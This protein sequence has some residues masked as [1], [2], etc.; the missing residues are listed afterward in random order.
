MRNAVF[1][2]LFATIITLA[3]IAAY[4]SPESGQTAFPGVNG[5]IAFS[6]FRNSEA[7]I[8]LINPVTLAES[9]VS[10]TNEFDYQPSF[11]PD[12]QKIAYFSGPLDT[13]GIHVLNLMTFD[14]DQITFEGDQFPSWSPDGMQIAFSRFDG[15]D[16]D[17]WI[18]DADGSNPT[19]VTNDPAED[20]EPAWSPD[21]NSIAFTSDRSG[22]EDVW[23]MPVAGGAATR[24][25][26]NP[27]SDRE[28]SWSPDGTMIAF[29]SDRGSGDDIYTT[30]WP[31]QA[32]GPAG[33]GGVNRL[34]NDPAADNLPAWSPDGTMVAFTSERDAGDRE[35][36]VMTSAGANQTRMT[37][38]A[39]FDWQPDW[40]PMP[41]A[42]TPTPTASPSGTPFGPPITATPAPG[43]SGDIDCDGD[44][45]A[46]DA[47]K[48][49]QDI[50]A[51]IAEPPCIDLGDVDCDGD[52]DAVDAQPILQW[53]AG[54]PVNLPAGCP[55]IGTPV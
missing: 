17:I 9:K 3:V 21:G 20:T 44:V 52:E 14:I 2:G 55:D 16:N 43:L 51:L 28:A 26:N 11:S 30:A 13:G 46:V 39:S 37:I 18:A 4:S 45:D 33:V 10:L 31:V 8:Y 50:A 27:G 12:G 48:I 34:T 5:Q 19:Q 1:F 35:I 23:V 24:V 42:P 41:V 15:S 32:G 22:N 40:G 53:L 36:Y 47:Q 6:T 49:L 54:F 38:S 29:A 7:D 25:T